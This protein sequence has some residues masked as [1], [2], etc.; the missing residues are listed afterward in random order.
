MLGAKRHW[1]PGPSL[2]PWLTLALTL[3]ALRTGWAQEGTEPVLLE[4]ECLVVCEPSRAAAGGPGGAALG[5]AP[6]GRV[7]FA[8]VRSHHHEP[9]GEIGN[10]TSGA[11]YF[12]QVLVNEGGGFDRASGSF[13]APVRGVYS[14]RFHVVKVYNRQTVQTMKRNMVYIPQRWKAQS[15]YPLYLSSFPGTTIEEAVFS[16]LYTL[17]S[18]IKDKVTICAWVYLWAFYPVPLIYISVPVSVPYCLDYCS[19]VV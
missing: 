18:F 10:G 3:M 16:P 19:L 17:A 9:A 8:A 1:P 11:I 5:E 7:A 14:F 13:V 6:P 12:D 4:G 15:K 2:S